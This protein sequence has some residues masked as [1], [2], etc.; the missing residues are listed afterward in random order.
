M[1]L[2]AL[3]L[4]LL[5]ASLFLAGCSSDDAKPEE[6]VQAFFAE[7]WDEGETADDYLEE[8]R[9]YLTDAAFKDSQEVFSTELDGQATINYSNVTV[10]NVEDVD[11]STARVTVS[12]TVTYSYQDKTEDQEQ[13]DTL[14]LNKV[15]GKWLLSE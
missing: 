4:P 13:T 8:L 1:K 2:R 9:P 14:T 7:S 3:A 5:A 6:T 15:D 12:Y 11:E 10:D